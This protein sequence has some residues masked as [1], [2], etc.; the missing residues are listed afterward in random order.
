MNKK[1]GIVITDGVGYRN[2]ILSDFLNQ[3]VGNFEEVIIYSGLSKKVYNGLN[4][5]NIKIYELDVYKESKK[6]WFFRRINEQAHLF[7]YKS[8]FG[9]QDTL[10]MTKPKGFTKRD[11]LN[12]VIRS[13]VSVFH[14][15][16]NMILYQQLL[17][18]SLSE[19]NLTKQLIKVITEHKPDL[20]FFT[21]QRP[22]YIA[23]LAYAAKTNNIKTCSFIFSWDNL[24]SKGRMPV[25]FDYFLVWSDLMKE[26]L[27]YFYPSVKQEVIHVVGTPQF[28]PYVMDKYKLSK[29]DFFTTFGIDSKKKTICFSCGDNVTGINDELSIEIIAKAIQSD[30]LLEKVNLIVR[31]SP[32]DDGSKFNKLIDKYTFISWNKPKWQLTR[33]NHPEPWSQ[34]IPLK[35]D[36]KELRAILEYSDLSINMCST[37]SLDFMLFDKPVINTVF[38]NKENGLYNDQKFLNFIHYKY[39]VNSNAVTVAKNEKEL[40]KYILEAMEYPSKRSKYRK[41]LLE[42]EIGKPLKGTSIQVV[43]GLKSMI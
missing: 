25:L 27:Q 42:L 23:P 7:K 13:F 2:F 5:Q 28:E 3:V 39:V 43:N 32:A 15:D 4:F 8:F 14:S 24:A 33:E 17:F 30:K 1:I 19:N 34:R 10:Q 21:H 36:I 11:I 41:E 26:E 18:K 16:K 38:G 6:A 40:H 22:P 9:M 37:M 12:R 29:S 31:T 35:Q 20:L